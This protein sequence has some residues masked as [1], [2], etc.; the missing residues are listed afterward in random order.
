MRTIVQLKHIMYDNLLVIT[1]ILYA[2]Q[3]LNERYLSHNL[4]RNMEAKKIIIQE[5]QI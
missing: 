5:H 1:R 4:S 3:F 2:S